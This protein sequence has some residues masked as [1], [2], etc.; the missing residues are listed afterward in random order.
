MCADVLDHR[1]LINIK[2]ALW[3]LH[4]KFPPDYAANQRLVKASSTY[5]RFEYQQTGDTNL[6]KLLTIRLRIMHRALYT[7]SLARHFVD[8]KALRN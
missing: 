7:R 3:K 5:I 8:V 4:D 6:N 1:A 2:R